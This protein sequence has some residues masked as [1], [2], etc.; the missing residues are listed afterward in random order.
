MTADKSVTSRKYAV[1]IKDVVR[2]ILMYSEVYILYR[3]L[4][5]CFMVSPSLFHFDLTPPPLLVIW[6]DLSLTIILSIMNPS[7]SYH[8]ALSSV[9]LVIIISEYYRKVKMPFGSGK[10]CVYLYKTMGIECHRIEI[11]YI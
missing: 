3:S 9:P 7:L 4:L 1:L 2:T 8:N 11:Q 6:T 10:K 5:S